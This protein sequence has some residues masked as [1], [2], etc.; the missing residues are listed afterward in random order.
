MSRSV[1]RRCSSVVAKLAGYS[2]GH[3]V[4][5]WGHEVILWV[6]RLF[7]GV[8]GYS[9]GHEKQKWFAP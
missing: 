1:V 5:L 2:L 8:G 7:S 6:T 9:L 3:E 4:I